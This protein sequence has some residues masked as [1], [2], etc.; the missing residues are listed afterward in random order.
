MDQRKDLALAVAFGLFG[1]AVLVI[2]LQ[3]PLGRIRDPIGPR[4]LPAVTGGLIVAFACV[5]AFRIVRRW[6]SDGNIVPG[7]GSS[8]L[9]GFPASTLRAMGVWAVLF[10][11]VLLL[12]AVG[13]LLLTPVLVAVLLWTM[14]VRRPLKLAV[15]SILAV[16]AM[17]LLFVTLLGV[18]L[19]MGPLQ[20]Y[21]P[22]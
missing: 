12:D 6:R 15:I 3:L 8:D 17:Y 16:A 2:A 21:L 14:R 13:F 5:V 20:P 22:I 1:A 4:T 7:E 10:C 19:P 11:Y 9:P 18:R